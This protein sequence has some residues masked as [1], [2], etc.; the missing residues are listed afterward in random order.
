MLVCGTMPNGSGAAVGAGGIGSGVT[1]V[2]VYGVPIKSPSSSGMYAASSPS[3][4][5]FTAPSLMYTLPESVVAANKVFF[6]ILPPF[7]TG[8]LPKLYHLR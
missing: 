2:G 4:M 3:G 7:F 1:T 6:H 5:I 8:E